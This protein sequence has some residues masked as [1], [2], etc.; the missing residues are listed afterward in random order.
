MPF[1]RFFDRGAKDAGRANPA[2]ESAELAEDNAPPED[3]AV[4]ED[5]AEGDEAVEH[6]E[7]DWVTRARAV[8]PTGASTGSKRIEALY[9]AA[10]AT[11]PTHFAQA[12]GCR[13][14]DVDGNEYLD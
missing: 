3:E 9:G 10:D 11:G 12:V 2:A 6:E 14:T 1:R 5:Q 13:V 7:A 4:E 8:L